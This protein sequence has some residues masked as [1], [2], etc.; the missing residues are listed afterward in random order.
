MDDDTKVDDYFV[1]YEI[2]Q[3]GMILIIPNNLLPFLD[4]S[5]YQF[6]D[7]VCI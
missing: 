1:T 7:E 3:F 4:V 2:I 5:C 6:L